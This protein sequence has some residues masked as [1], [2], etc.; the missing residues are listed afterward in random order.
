MGGK[1]W[2]GASVGTVIYIIL[3]AVAC[4]LVFVFR[5]RDKILGLSS[6]IL[7]GFCLW[8]LWFM[9]YISQINPYGPPEVKAE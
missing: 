5:M 9:T 3:T 2:I 1:A 4:G 7:A 8:F 6:C